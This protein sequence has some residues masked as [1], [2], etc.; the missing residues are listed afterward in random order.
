MVLNLNKTAFEILSRLESNLHNCRFKLCV[1]IDLSLEKAYF[2]LSRNKIEIFH[3][4]PNKA[5]AMHYLKFF[6]LYWYVME[7]LGATTIKIKFNLISL[8]RI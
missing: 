2:L 3:L 6:L 5:R 1:Y 7:T 8:E 4:T